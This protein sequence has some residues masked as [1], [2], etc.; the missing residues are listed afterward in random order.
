M[1]ARWSAAT[2]TALL[3]IVG[4]ML[5]TVPLVGVQ[6]PAHTTP[7]DAVNV[8]FAAAFWYTMLRAR[9]PETMPLA[10]PFWMIVMGGVIGLYVAR[11]R[12]RGL[13]VIGQDVYLY[14]WFVATACMLANLRRLHAVLGLWAGVAAVV[15]ALA[16]IDLYTG[17]LGGQ[18]AAGHSRASGTFDNPNMF[19][20]YL[21]VSVFFTWTLAASG[22][23]WFWLLLPVLWLGM[24]ATASNGSLVSLVA[25]ATV[26]AAAHPTH[27]P[28]VRV[29]LAL[30]TVGLAVGLA[31]LFH[32][33]TAARIDALLNRDRGEVGGAAYKGWEARLPVWSVVPELV[34]QSPGGVGPGNFGRERGR[35]SGTYHSAHNEYLGMLVERGPLGFVGWCALLAGVAG[36]LRP[37][38]RANRI[39]LRRVRVEP[40]YGLVAALAVHALVIEMFHFRHVWLAFAVL[41]ALGAQARAEVAAALPAPAAPCPAEADEAAA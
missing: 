39:G 29:G 31:A 11:E 18:F 2:E 1:T 26:A 37:V 22:R 32:D 35:L 3:T 13:L 19:G 9:R 17:R 33:Q 12:A 38:R 10:L 28:G 36:F 34:V 14:L 15:A 30:A 20:D 4:A 16:V 7:M 24:L 27:R 6:G 23:P 21:V 25:G 5:V 41:R 40:L 8:I